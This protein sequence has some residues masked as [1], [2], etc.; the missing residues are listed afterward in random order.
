MKYTNFLWLSLIALMI[1]ACTPKVTETL[2]EN[3]PVVVE[4][5][6]R[7]LDELV[8][9]APR[10]Y[11][12][13]TYNPSYTRTNDLIHTKL[14]V[15]FDF[16]KQHV[17]GK[18]TLDLEPYFYPTKTVTLDAKGFDIHKVELKNGTALT[19]DYKDD[20][21]MIQLD[22]EYQPKEKYT[23]YI[24]YTAKPNERTVGGSAAI[25][26]DKGLY[27]I[28][29]KGETPNKPTQIWTQGETE[30]N[31]AWF[32][33]IDKPNERC[34]QEITVTIR[35]D[36]E[37]LSN[38]VLKSSK[39]NGDGTR[40]DY[41]VMDMP[42]APYLFMLAIG[43]FAVVKEE[44]RG[45]EVA[46]YVEK[47]YE[48]YAKRI[49]PYTLEMLD[50][51]S[52]LYGYDYPWQKYSQVVVRD[53]V[54]GAMENTTGVIFGE[55]MHGTERELIDEKNNERIVAHE[56]VHHWFGDLV[57]CESWANLPMNE[58]FANYGEYLWMEKKHGKEEGDYHLMNEL[59]GY[60]AQ[61]R[62]STH[63]L[64]YFDY[65]DKEQTFDAHSYN[66]GGCILHSL[67]NYVGDEA[68]FAALQHYLK[69]NEF[70]AVEAHDL[71][72]SFEE[73]TGQDLNWFFNQWFF[74]TGHP[75]LEVSQ[76]YDATNQ[77]VVLTISQTQDAEQNEPIY[78]LPIAIDVYENDKP[79][80]HKVLINKRKQVFEFDA[81]TAPKL[82]NVDADKILVG[83]I[84][85]EK[86]PEQLVFQYNNANN[87]KSRYEALSGLESEES[88]EAKAVFASALNDSH[89]YLRA[90][91]VQT[92][93]VGDKMAD[94]AV[95]DAHSAVR[96]EAME[97]LG[98]SKNEAFIPTLKKGIDKDLAY[99]VIASGL[100]GLT[101]L[102]VNSAKAYA[103]KM[104]K[105]EN[106]TI[107]GAVGNTYATLG[108]VS[109]LEYFE[110]TWTK[111]NGF[112]ISDF[113]KNY[114][115]LL[116]QADDETKV[117]A[118]TKLKATSMN[119]EA[120]LWQRYATTRTV[121]G[122]KKYFESGIE[123]LSKEETKEGEVNAELE[124]V[125]IALAKVTAELTEIIDWE[126]NGQLKGIYANWK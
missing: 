52:E 121:Y 23:L 46:Y 30:S 26:Q 125:K 60:L 109:K 110:N 53:Y 19:Y 55:F 103:E 118:I 56:L 35:E 63:D 37:T 81:A 74:A 123:A 21:L 9:S 78:Q 85:H 2:E 68:F 45:K 6:E 111:I 11:K 101:A 95:N 3:E 7:T 1:S 105:E 10:T 117:A 18:A 92:A 34:T 71:R 108:D 33:T 124:K 76:E 83:T 62:T 64:I 112:Q 44:W 119:E 24:E 47:K 91:A 39:S 113:M 70:T 40:S 97:K 48:Q 93:V 116:I 87:F 66:K 79:T 20:M 77:K 73:I 15:R 58:S 114:D 41:W 102:D 16:D 31:S 72:L 82:V 25:T 14:D 29:P 99:P 106:A 86:T 120:S 42:H 98:A 61:A 54:S 96:A 57:T 27:F 32:P 88:D 38:G 65:K 28:N 84:K 49:F 107:L 51:Y 17:L 5:E 50:F 67:R 90:K 89:W 100:K 122:L 8:V 36:F 13:P 75:E 80:R 22:K 104:E 43:D 59:N 94:L 4:I 12:L 126:T 69:T 115:K